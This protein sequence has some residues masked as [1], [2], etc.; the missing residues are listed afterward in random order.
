MLDPE[1]QLKFAAIKLN[2]ENLISSLFFI[3]ILKK[4]ANYN[5]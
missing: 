3:E 5:E 4:T 2:F 1:K